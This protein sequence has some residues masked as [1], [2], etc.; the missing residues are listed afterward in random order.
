MTEN[1]IDE[2]AGDPT[3]FEPPPGLR[4]ELRDR[5]SDE[6]NGRPVTVAVT[7]LDDDVRRPKRGW[8]LAA[9]AVMVL[10]VVGLVV[11]V[12]AGDR[13][14]TVVTPGPTDEEGAGG[15]IQ[16]GLREIPLEVVVGLGGDDFDGI[17]VDVADIVAASGAVGLDPPAPGRT[18]KEVIESLVALNSPTSSEANTIGLAIPFPGAIFVSMPQLGPLAAET[19]IELGA[20]ES[21]VSISAVLG[22]PAGPGDPEFRP[23]VS[24][25][26]DL[27]LSDQLV[28]LGDGIVSVGTGDDGEA[29]PETR[30]DL[31]P[32]GRPLRLAADGDAVAFSLSTPTIAAWLERDS[33]T[34]LADDPRFAAVAAALDDAGSVAAEISSLDFTRSSGDLPGEPPVADDEYVPGGFGVVGIGMVPHADRASNAMVYLFDDEAAAAESVDP[35]ETSWSDPGPDG[36]DG[37]IVDFESIERDG[38]IVTV[39]VTPIDGRSTIAVLDGVK[40]EVPQ[41]RHL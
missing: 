40:F 27:E 19:G 30:T 4:V 20:I 8:L 2:L 24:F 13:D 25:T 16:R 17:V 14:G 18:E 6:W 34:T 37:T 10:L 29:S 41:F 21:G 7:E 9:A 1:W 35:L 3:M 23:F 33:G 28:P 36:F 12:R 32:V 5:L 22:G 39:I 11:V 26:G 31:R 15:V 38:A